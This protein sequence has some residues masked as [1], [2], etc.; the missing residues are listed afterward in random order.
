MT[1][2]EKLNKMFKE[3]PE[4]GI[5]KY[6]FAPPLYRLLWRIG[7]EIPP[8][9]FSSFIFLFIFEGLLF[10]IPWG[11]FMWLFERSRN[12]MSAISYILGSIFAGIFFGLIMAINFRRQAKKYNLPLWKDYGKD[13]KK[14]L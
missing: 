6:E 13:E 8:P 1:H 4:R 5:R 11:V 14:V 10:G 2:K 3:L 12:V 9:L 7:I